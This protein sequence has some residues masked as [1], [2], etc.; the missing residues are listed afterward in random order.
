[1]FLAVARSSHI[2][3]KITECHPSADSLTKYRAFSYYRPQGVIT[4]SDFTNWVSILLV[5]VWPN[6]Y[7]AI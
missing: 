7:S 2:L 5:S 6:F 4:L 3:N 1:M